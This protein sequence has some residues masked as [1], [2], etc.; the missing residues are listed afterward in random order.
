M[1]QGRPFPHPG[2]APEAPAEPDLQAAIRVEQ[3]RRYRRML[4]G[5][6]LAQMAAAALVAATSHHAAPAWV[7]LLWLLLTWLLPAISLWRWRP[8]R[9]RPPATS[10]PPAQIRRLAATSTIGGLI[11]GLSGFLFYTP[12]LDAHQLVLIGVASGNPAAAV[13]AMSILP[14][15]ALGFSAAHLAP[16]AL[17]LTMAGGPEHYAFIALLALYMAFLAFIVRGNYRAFRE[18]VAAE[19][20]IRGLNDK[21]ARSADMLNEVLE[22]ISDGFV[23]FD[24][25]DR[26]VFCNDKFRHANPL[27]SDL[28]VPGTRFE[29]LVRAIAARKAVNI[30]PDMVEDWIARRVA[31]HRA[32]DGSLEFQLADGRWFLASDRRTARG[33]HVGIRTDITEKKT[34]EAELRRARDELERRIDDR[35]R[36]LQESHDQLRLITDSVPAA[37]AYLDRGKRFVFVNNTGVAWTATTRA[38]IL[39]RHVTEVLPG[40]SGERIARR[41]D[42]ALS[43]ETVRYEDQIV[44]PDGRIRDVAGSHIPHV[45]AA[46]I[47]R[48]CFTLVH[49]ITDQ[50]Q[51]Q[52]ELTQAKEAAEQADRMKSEF[53]ANM[54]HELRTPLNAVIGFSEMLALGIYG[55]LNARQKD[56]VKA[57]GARGKALLAIINDILDITDIEAGRLVPRERDCDLRRLMD[58]VRETVRQEAAAGSLT[59]DTAVD[60][61]IGLFRGDP[62]LI[63]TLLLKLTANAVKFTPAGGQVTLAARRDRDGGVTLSVRDTGIGMA[64]QDMPKAMSVFGQVDGTLTRKFEGAGL[65]LTLAKAFTDLHGGKLTIDSTV[66]GG[67]TVSVRFPPARGA[68][69][70]GGRR[71]AAQSGSGGDS[72]SG[73]GI[74]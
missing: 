23:W 15:A 61:A 30:P 34:I 58:E 42:T 2:G 47:T 62:G 9:H 3:M 64:E 22:N 71:T 38:R 72:P 57:I 6:C 10:V 65:G 19:L 11:W 60:P 24:A 67:T 51:A 5:L 70:Q 26:L 43:G 50:K 28:F 35:T 46:G 55:D 52:R 8:H 21:L 36:A 18:R 63:R 7:V 20:A 39:G 56:T 74:S 31:H 44:Y 27:V 37:L 25:D 33:D 54:G 29:D 48:G 17:R 66:G 14:A 12:T 68:R 45:D 32:G 1:R 4:P 49:D 59:I 41:L 13:G 16:L 40:P 53:F 69:R 73:S